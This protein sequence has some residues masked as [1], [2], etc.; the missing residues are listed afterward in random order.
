MSPQL[1]PK[2]T[3]G[4]WK[5]ITALRER[6]V[7]NSNASTPIQKCVFRYTEVNMCLFRLRTPV[8]SLVILA[9]FAAGAAL[10]QNQ[11]QRQPAKPAATSTIK[12]EDVSKWTQKQWDAAKAKW[13]EE[14]AKWGDCQKQSTKAKLSGRK[15]WQ[16]IYDCMTK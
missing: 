14:K 11:T 8:M 7:L 4:N 9:Y 2:L 15:S 10:A 1:G 16:F 13:S 6:K 12:M 3:C 5:R